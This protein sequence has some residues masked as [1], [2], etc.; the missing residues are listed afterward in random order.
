MSPSAPQKKRT[1]KLKCKKKRIKEYTKPF[2]E[3]EAE[4]TFDWCVELQCCI[5]V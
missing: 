1:Q 5:T 2:G 3:S 4:V